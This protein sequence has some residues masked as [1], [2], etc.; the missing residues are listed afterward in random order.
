MTATATWGDNQGA[1]AGLETG[2]MR[3][4]MTT[5]LIAKPEF[6]SDF[7]SLLH[8]YQHRSWRR[9]GDSKEDGWH[10]EDSL[11]ICTTL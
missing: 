5:D 2:T 9:A 7:R 8:F 11:A 3:L 1:K 6:A 10:H 4:M